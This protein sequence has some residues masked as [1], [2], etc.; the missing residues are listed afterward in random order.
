VSSATSAAQPLEGSTH[1]GS[2][3]S[4]RLRLLL[5]GGPLL[6]LGGAVV[7]LLLTPAAD[8]GYLI[9]A[10]VLPAV[11]VAFLVAG[12]RRSGALLVAAALLNVEA[13]VAGALLPEG[14]VVAIVAPM[15]G[16]ALI[17]DRLPARTQLWG[18][19]SAGIAATV[20]VSLAVVVGPASVLFEG[21]EAWVTI[22]S[23]SALVTFALALDWR[24]T[25]RLR[26][27]RD[28]AEAELAARIRA[29]QAL[30]HTSDLLAAIVDASPLAVQAF[31]LDR[32]VTVWNAGSERIF[33]WT[34]EEL[35]GHP[36]P[37]GMIPDDERESAGERIRR[38]IE[39][40]AIRGDRV[41][42]LT[43]DGRE[44]WIEIYGSAIYDRDGRPL[45]LA[46]QLAD[47]TE[48]VALDAQLAHAQRLEAIGRLAGGV[49]HDFNNTLSA[50]GGFAALIADETADAEAVRADAA[51]I[52]DVV[53][54]SRQLTGQLL[55]FARRSTLKPTVLDLGAVVAD[56]ES[57]LSRL[58]DPGI[59][60]EIH[61]AGEPLVARVDAGLLEQTLANL[62][63]NARDAMPDGGRLTVRVG[64]VDVEAG[65]V[66]DDPAASGR[67]VEVAVADTG[68]GIEPD[69][70]P[71]VFEPFF[72]T[73]APG[74]GTG[75]G[76]ALVRDFVRRSD[77]HLS[78]DT[79]VGKGTTFRIRFP[80]AM[81]SRGD[82][83]DRD[84]THLA[85]DEAATVA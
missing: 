31:T 33:G 47:V 28:A 60:L 1:P 19:V 63:V 85:D 68:T 18:S 24:V 71:S 29:E 45:G 39:G 84:P 8:A 43:K 26:S 61:G 75:L 73:K 35:I 44:L 4:P 21:K 59:E 52:I 80:E 10:V 16:V 30:E 17:V 25:H 81:P 9:A 5:I 48:R 54:R 76:L 66:R 65:E 42:R 83:S 20:G 40:E 14:I 64:A 34:A 69:V 15:I 7:G 70:L 22:A 36:M 55:A 79:A 2:Q 49:A 32:T 67:F 12:L 51:S 82:R 3:E 53:A 58:L 11:I 46:G 37:A 74:Q 72:T 50:I 38:T 57:V 77:G 27:A 13:I 78:I 6:A 56:L 62:V 41:R 23:F